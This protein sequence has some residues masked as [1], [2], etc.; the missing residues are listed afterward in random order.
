MQHWHPGIF[1]ELPL[2]LKVLKCHIS[3]FGSHRDDGGGGCLGLFYTQLT[4][5]K[6]HTHR[7][8]ELWTA[9]NLSPACGA[10]NQFQE[11]SLELSSQAT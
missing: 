10:S 5:E 8:L 2:L 9:E 7:H 6:A 11:P 4:L 1:F 3:S